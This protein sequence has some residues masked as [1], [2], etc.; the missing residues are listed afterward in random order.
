MRLPELT[1][2]MLDA[3]GDQRRV[4]TEDPPLAAMGDGALLAPN[5]AAVIGPD[6]ETWIQSVSASA[7]PSRGPAESLDSAPRKDSV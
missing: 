7:A 6:V 1:S 2:K 5:H 3:Q 4:R